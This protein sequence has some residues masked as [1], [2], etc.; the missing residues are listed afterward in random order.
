MTG[1]LRAIGWDSFV[2]EHHYFSCCAGTKQPFLQVLS[3]AERLTHRELF[4]RSQ[5]NRM[6]LWGCC[7]MNC[8]EALTWFRGVPPLLSY[9][10][11]YCMTC[12]GAAAHYYLFTVDSALSAYTLIC[13]GV[14]S[15]CREGRSRTVGAFTVQ[16]KVSWRKKVPGYCCSVVDLTSS[17]WVH[18]LA[19]VTVWHTWAL[20]PVSCTAC[21]TLQDS[22]KNAATVWGDFVWYGRKKD[23]IFSPKK[24]KI[25][26][27]IENRIVDRDQREP[28]LFLLLVLLFQCIVLS[29]LTGALDVS[30]TSLWS[31]H[32][33]IT[34]ISQK[35]RWS[36]LTGWGC[37]DN[38]PV[39][40]FILSQTYPDLV[41]FSL[42]FSL[43]F[44]CT[45]ELQT[46]LLDVKL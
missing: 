21:A 2:L 28:A 40:K 36:I 15:V 9:Q 38:T 46:L 35:V 37:V 12:T 11:M 17:L 10:P 3:E 45:S 1:A 13:R 25:V 41:L 34:F 16:T 7:G 42:N 14:V 19:P 43:L 20:K 24:Q 22:S 32:V 23:W 29:L 18:R 8:K 33:L 4:E 30:H 39:V 5:S 31:D 26:K 6:L 27:R 44:L